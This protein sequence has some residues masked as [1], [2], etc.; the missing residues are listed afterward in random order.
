MDKMETSLPLKNK[1]L[2][3]NV[4]GLQNP[5]DIPVYTL[6]SFLI[7][8]IRQSY[9]LLLAGKWKEITVRMSIL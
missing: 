9:L 2:K 6:V 8:S 1:T 3:L 4:I 7:A 5:L